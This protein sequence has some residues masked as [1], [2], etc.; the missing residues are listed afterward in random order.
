MLFTFKQKKLCFQ[1]G[2]YKCPVPPG[3]IS[4]FWTDLEW[5]RHIDAYGEWCH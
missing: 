5:C 3:E 1:K 2:L 4:K